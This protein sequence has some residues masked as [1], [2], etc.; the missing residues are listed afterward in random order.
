MCVQGCL[1][2]CGCPTVGIVAGCSIA[3]T[4]V[5]LHGHETFLNLAVKHP[6]VY[7]DVFVDDICLSSEG[8]SEKQ[9]IH[10]LVKLLPS[11]KLLT[12]HRLFS[13]IAPYIIYTH[14]VFEWSFQISEPVTQYLS[15]GTSLTH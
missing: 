14:C 1:S 10:N 4:F 12:N 3:T 6:N 15:L 9:V 11:E 5:H 7:F 2:A 13:W 8:K